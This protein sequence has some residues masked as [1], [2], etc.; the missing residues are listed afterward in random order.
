M[1]NDLDFDGMNDGLEP[2]NNQDMPPA[3][4]L[5]PPPAQ[6]A[7]GGNPVKS[8]LDQSLNEL[9]AAQTRLDDASRT[10]FEAEK[11]FNGSWIR[12]G[13]ESPIPRR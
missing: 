9:N 2:D 4:P 12:Q 13:H 7:A 11:G 8:P 5:Q 10:H 6:E 1:I 3:G